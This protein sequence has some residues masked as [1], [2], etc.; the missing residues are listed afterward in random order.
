PRYDV[1]LGTFPHHGTLNVG[2]SYTEKVQLTVPAEL[3]TGVPLPSGQYEITPWADSSQNVVKQT[4]DVNLNPDAPTDIDGDNFKARPINVLAGAGLP[5]LAVTAVHADAHVAAG[6][7]I[8]VSWTVQNVG[9][10]PTTLPQ[11]YDVVYL[12][13]APVLGTPGDR[14]IR[15][16]QVLHSSPL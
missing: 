8:N 14:E 15:L 10:G 13:S 12:S 5:D 7:P 4:R 2:Q 1:L 9:L 16:A 11:W 6:N 3:P